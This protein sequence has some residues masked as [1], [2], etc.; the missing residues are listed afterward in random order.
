MYKAIIFDLDNTLLDYDRSELESMEGVRSAHDLFEGDDAGW[1]KFLHAF[2]KRSYHYWTDFTSDGETKHILDVLTFA[3]A[4]TLEG[5]EQSHRQYAATYWELFCHS[6]HFEEGA[7]EVLS[8]VK[9]KYKLGIIT[10]GISEAQRKRLVATKLDKLF[11]S[12]VIS[13]EVDVRKPDEEIFAIALRELDLQRS[14][15]LYV[16]D[17]LEDDYIGARNVGID[18]CLYNGRGISVPENVLPKVV[19]E[20]LRELIQIL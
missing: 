19:I 15:V 17:S 3:F 11:A 9:D 6:D 1:M 10:N 18:F 7:E 13:D 8:Y 2:K 16:G 12:V 14:E 20:D 4:D 5:D